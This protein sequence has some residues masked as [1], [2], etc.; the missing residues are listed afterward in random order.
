MLLFFFVFDY[1]PGCVEK[2]AVCGV[3]TAYFL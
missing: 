3:A 1:T 2:Q